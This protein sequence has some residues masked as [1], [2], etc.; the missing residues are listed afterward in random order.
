MAYCTRVRKSLRTH[1][2]EDKRTALEALAIRGTWYTD[3]DVVI[4]GF[5]SV[6]IENTCYD[7]AH[8]TDCLRECWT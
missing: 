6:N 2:L 3:R 8:D 1:T 4:E 7:A 5:I